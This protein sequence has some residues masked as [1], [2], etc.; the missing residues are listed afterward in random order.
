[1][2]QW[3]AMKSITSTIWCLALAVAVTGCGR[4]GTL[5]GDDASPGADWTVDTRTDTIQPDAPLP[6]GPKTSTGSWISIKPGTYFMG[7]PTS[8]PC[9]D[10]YDELRHMVVLT[11]GFEIWSTEVTQG[12]YKKVMGYNPSVAK[13]C[14]AACPVE[15]VTWHE[16][17]AYCAV[18]SKNLGKKECYSCKGN[19][20]SMT[21]VLFY[22]YPTP[23]DCAGYRLPTETEYEY[24]TRAGSTTA[25]Y[26]GKIS[27]CHGSDA[28]ANKIGWYD[29][30][31]GKRPHPVAGKQPNAWG[32]YDLAGNV[33]EWCHDWYKP[34]GWGAAIKDPVGPVNGKHRVVRFGSFLSE[35][36]TLRSAN[37]S[38][39]E[40]HDRVSFTGFR[41]V[42]TLP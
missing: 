10:S 3:I 28:N 30:N 18:L 8:E 34:F 36:R 19:S 27:T 38:G 9:R 16:A 25:L 5:L 12:E 24:A 41:C 15:N 11:R 2:R 32:L 40:P 42:R 35:A 39:L 1:M 21:C 37:R 31:S 22:P 14:G 20:K 13:T 33:G 26:N 6:D 23:Y 17:A 29:K 7:S 4:S